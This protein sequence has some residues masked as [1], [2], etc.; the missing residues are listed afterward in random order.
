M[1]GEVTVK[2]M[3]LLAVNPPTTTLIKPVVAPVGTVTVRLVDVLAVTV[4]GVPLKRTVL[5][6]GM[7][8]KFV[9]VITTVL[10][11]KPEEGLKEEIVGGRTELSTKKVR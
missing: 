2:L 11:T 9:P 10:P 6:A 5:L 1:L 7:V 3:P 4:A 8:E